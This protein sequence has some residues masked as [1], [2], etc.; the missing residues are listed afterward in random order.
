MCIRKLG[1][2][3]ASFKSDSSETVKRFL[4]S[5]TCSAFQFYRQYMQRFISVFDSF[6]LQ[7]SPRDCNRVADR[8]V[9]KAYE[10]GSY[11]LWIR[12]SVPSWLRD[13]VSSNKLAL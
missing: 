13:L 7:F 12:N 3:K 8:L 10:F 4:N 2:E 9:H 11:V 5:E 6:S 1:Y